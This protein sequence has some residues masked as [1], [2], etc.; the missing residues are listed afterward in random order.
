ML[1]AVLVAEYLEELR[2]VDFNPLSPQL[3]TPRSHFWKQVRLL[4]SV[5]TA[6]I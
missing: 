3:L 2:R 4:K 5:V 6:R 1:P